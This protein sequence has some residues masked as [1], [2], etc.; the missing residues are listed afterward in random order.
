MAWPLLL[1]ADVL[2]EQSEHA[3]T[4][5]IALKDN[6]EWKQFGKIPH[7]D[8]AQIEKDINRSLNTYD[9]CKRWNKM[10]KQ[11]RREQLSMMI[12]AILNKNSELYYYQGYHDYVSVF[13]LTL[14]DN[15]GYYCAKIA[16]NYL[17]RDFMNETFESGVLPALDLTSKLIQLIDIDLWNL[18]EQSGGQ[19]NFAVSWILTWFSHDIDH[20]EKVQLIFDACLAT[21]PLFNCY[22]TVA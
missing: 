1:N 18:I 9:I 22:I 8:S 17:I 19:P 16:S 2:S 12:T 14:G 6:S 21:H 7:K 4:Y 3:K 20:F 13:L 5:K 10:M 11:I 15:L